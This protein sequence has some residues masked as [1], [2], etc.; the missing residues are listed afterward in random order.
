MEVDVDVEWLKVYLVHVVNFLG[1]RKW[2]NDYVAIPLDVSCYK[3]TEAGLQ[4]IYAD[5]LE[6]FSENT[7]TGL[8]RKT[9]LPGFHIDAFRRG[10]AVLTRRCEKE[11]EAAVPTVF[12]F[13]FVNMSVMLWL[14]H[15]VGAS[16]KRAFRKNE[17]EGYVKMMRHNARFLEYFNRYVGRELFIKQNPSDRL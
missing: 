2:G 1:A 16:K 8:A 3:P 9:I 14:N 11:G 17:I 10:D 5:V 6:K 7:A 4:K 15:T 13:I 12:F